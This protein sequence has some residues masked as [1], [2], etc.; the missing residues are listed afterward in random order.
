[1]KRINKQRFVEDLSHQHWE[2]IVVKEDSDLMWS[3]WKK[4]FLGV[5]AQTIQPPYSTSQLQLHG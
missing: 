5:L 2:Q 4:L 1:M 3:C